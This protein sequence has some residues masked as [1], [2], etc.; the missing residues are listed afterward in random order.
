MKVMESRLKKGRKQ[1][2]GDYAAVI[3]MRIIYDVEVIMVS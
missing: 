2:F 1:S 3:I